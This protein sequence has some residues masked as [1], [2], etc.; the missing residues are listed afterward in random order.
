MTAAKLIVLLIF[1]E[2]YN[3]DFLPVMRASSTEEIERARTLL[4][5]MLDPSDP[6]Y[7]SGSPTPVTVVAFQ[8]ARICAWEA[9]RWAKDAI[10]N[11]LAT[12]RGR[13]N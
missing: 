2:D 9:V 12:R 4:A 7:L 6:T 11:E 1:T 13:G 8:P 5:K 10:D 3:R